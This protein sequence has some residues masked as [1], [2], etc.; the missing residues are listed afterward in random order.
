MVYIPYLWKEEWVFKNRGKLCAAGPLTILLTTLALTNLGRVFLSSLLPPGTW[1]VLSLRVEW[2]C[3]LS[4]LRC[5]LDSTGGPFQQTSAR[6]QRNVPAPGGGARLFMCRCWKVCILGCIPSLLL[7]HISRVRLCVTP[8]MA[9]YQAPPS[10]GFS[11]QELWSGL[12]F[13][14]P[15]H[16]SEKWKWS[17]SV[18]SDS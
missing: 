12:P 17:R 1:W 8:W 7:S 10:L 14:S 16:E 2:V 13:P 5:R 15:M 18:M 4:S 9:A 6:M 11:R 3:W